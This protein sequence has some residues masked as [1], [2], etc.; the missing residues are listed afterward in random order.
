MRRRQ[1][2]TL[3]GGAV[4]WPLA[5]RAQQPVSVI[6]FLSS[7][8]P[9]ESANLVAAFREGLRETGFVEGQVGRK[10]VM[11]SYLHLP[12]KLLVYELRSFSRLGVPRQHSQPKARLRQFQS[13]SLRLPI[14]FGVAW[15][16]A[17][18]DPAA[19]SRA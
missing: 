4:A 15:S 13:F 17:S 7:R 12:P 14:R 3:L 2:I 1:F 10:V 9:G 18:A 8:S 5:A 6:G 19:T 11:S 16:P